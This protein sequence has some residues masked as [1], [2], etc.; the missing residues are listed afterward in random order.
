[1]KR[2]IKLLTVLF[3]ASVVSTAGA[4]SAVESLFKPV[5][6]IAGTTLDLRGTAQKRFLWMKALSAGFYFEK[7]R[8]L[9]DPLDDS[10][11]MIEC[12]YYVH[13]KRENINNFTIKIIKENISEDEYQ[14]IQ[15]EISVMHKYFVD[16]N[17]G[18]RFTMVYVPEV[19]TQF[20]YNNN[21]TGM[22]KGAAF[23]KAL[24]S[25][26]LGAKPFDE[27]LKRQILTTNA[28]DP[29]GDS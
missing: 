14:A 11:K 21:Y 8:T 25:T 15:P 3:L 6:H 19:G 22:I 23:S 18:D 27:S 29:Q 13:I 2:P 10:A 16:L 4:S 20:Y 5:A 17:P 12:E 7:G 9:E 1:V 28:I 24:F 26:W